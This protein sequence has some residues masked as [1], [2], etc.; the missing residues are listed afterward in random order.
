MG[1]NRATVTNTMRLLG[2][3]DSVQELLRDR[4]LSSGHGRALLSLDSRAEQKKLA[5]K[6]VAGRLSVRQT[7]ELT[8]LW[9]LSKAKPS[10]KKKSLALE[11][12]RSVKR[13]GQ[14]LGAKTRTRIA[15][16]KV[17]VELEFDS[18]DGIKN[19]E[20]ILAARVK[21]EVDA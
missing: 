3:P 9:Q 7:E 17:K 12:R 21:G 18:V 13:I 5:A 6:V 15:G 19:M 11:I 16:D 1:K 4:S 2:L 14:S 8:R 10:V 20:N